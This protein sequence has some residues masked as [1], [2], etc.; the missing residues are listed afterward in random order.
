[1]PG[2]KIKATGKDSVGNFTF[3]G[4]FDKKNSNFKFLKQYVGQHQIF[5]HGAFNKSKY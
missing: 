3:D 2:G 1:M 4:G 5:Y